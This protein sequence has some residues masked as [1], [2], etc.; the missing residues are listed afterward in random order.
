MPNKEDVSYSF[1]PLEKKDM[2]LLARW[3]AAPHVAQ[4][5]GDKET[6]LKGIEEDIDSIAVEPFIIELDGKP[7]GYIQS[8]DPYLDDGEN[9]FEDQPTGTLGIDQFIGEPDLIG[10]GHGTRL[11]GE[12]VE[13]LFEEGAPRVIIDPDTANTVAIRVYEKVGFH[14]V[15]RFK[16]AT[17]EALLMALDAED[18]ELPA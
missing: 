14:P 10:K 15:R 7:I 9:P 1:R 12:F 17:G 2:P 5:W 18:E 4:W 6:E 16:T 8:Y 11:I 3:L 13:M